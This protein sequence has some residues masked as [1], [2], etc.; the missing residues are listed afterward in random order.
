MQTDQLFLNVGANQLAMTLQQLNLL[1]QAEETLKTKTL[2]QAAVA[3][4]EQQAL[5]GIKLTELMNE[6]V[7]CIAQTLKVEYCKI[8][9]LL[10]NGEALLLRA[11]V[12]WHKSLVGRATFIAGTE[13]QAGYTLLVS[14][15]VVVE[16]LRSEPRFNE[17]SL[18]Y[19]HNLI[20]GL[21]VIIPGRG[22]PFGVLEAHTT[23]RRIFTHDDV[24]FLQDMANTV[25]TAIERKQA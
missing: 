10:P 25:A 13:S 1:K 16:D 8:L 12:G 17:P 23:K 7:V 6:A 2:Q 18:L 3:R 9:E 19:D 15:P 22:Q 24:H 20:S 11:G 14:E 21:S 4:L 5:A